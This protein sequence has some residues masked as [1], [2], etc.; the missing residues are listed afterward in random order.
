M[1]TKWSISAS[2]ICRRAA[3][4]FDTSSHQTTCGSPLT[5][6]K[7]YGSRGKLSQNSKNKI[8]HPT[9]YSLFLVG[10]SSQLWDVTSA[11]ARPYIYMYVYIFINRRW[12]MEN[13]GGAN[14][15][16]WGFKAN[17]ELKTASGITV[18]GVLNSLLENLNKNDTRPLIPLG[19]GDPSAFPSFRTATVAV[20]A[21]VHSVRSARFN[22]YSSTV[23]IL[24]ARRYLHGDALHL[25]LV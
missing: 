6:V 8:C 22:C 13:G 2:T 18:R 11:S 1:K 23:G 4:S 12:K 24:P 16:Q 9:V 7:N 15:N 3:T 14:G 19:H 17:E 20:D 5:F 21:I 10:Y 25:C